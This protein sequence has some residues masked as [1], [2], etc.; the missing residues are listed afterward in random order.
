MTACRDKGEAVS[1]SK[2]A[3]AKGSEHGPCSGK[4]GLGFTLIELLVV[5]AVIALLMAILTPVLHRAREAARRT[6]CLG[7]LR[8]MQVGWQ[9][10]AEDHDGLIVNG[11]AW[12]VAV[13][14]FNGTPFLIGTSQLVPHPAS[15]AEA[16]ALMRTGAL[17]SYVGS[18]GVY[19]CPSRYRQPVFADPSRF[20]WPGT[21]WLSSYG[22]VSSMNCF[23]IDERAAFESAFTK[24]HGPSR[25]PL[26][27]TRLAE[28]NPPGASLRIVFLDGGFPTWHPNGGCGAD[29][30]IFGLNGV[31]DFSETRIWAPIHH[32]NGT[33]MSFADGHGQYWKW[34]D[35]RTVPMAQACLDWYA[36]GEAVMPSPPP[37]P[38]NQDRID[39]YQA[40][41]GRRP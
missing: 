11:E 21:E 2:R 6:A 29:Y 25:V 26:Y 38:E 40:I 32:G 13:H 27:V 9:A 37:D 41:W 7:N 18:A 39:L 22:I 31:I 34:K 35:P 16:D 1:A 20:R 17:A 3:S 19:H 23:R 24:R 33:C 8:Q 28:L 5:I 15:L 10:Y 14:A 30:M 4:A 36:G 12:D